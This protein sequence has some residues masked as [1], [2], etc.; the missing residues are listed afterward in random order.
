MGFWRG[1][2]QFFGIYDRYPEKIEQQDIDNKNNMIIELKQKFE[3]HIIYKNKLKYDL[4]C[5]QLKMMHSKNTLDMLVNLNIK[6][7]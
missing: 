4:V 5:L 6:L 2:Y 3:E 7:I 1:A